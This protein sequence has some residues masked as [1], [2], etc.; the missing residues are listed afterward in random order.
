MPLADTHALRSTNLLDLAVA[1]AFIGGAIYL[2]G[3]RDRTEGDEYILKGWVGAAIVLLAVY[4]GMV[5]FAAV[6]SR[7]GT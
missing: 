4:G 2:Y 6:V 3:R 7:W 5:L 1:L